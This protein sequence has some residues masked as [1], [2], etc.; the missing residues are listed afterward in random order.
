MVEQSTVNRLAV[1][2]IPTSGAHRYPRPHALARLRAVRERPRV[3]ALNARASRNPKAIGELSEMAAALH[4]MRAG[5]DVAQ[6]F[7]DNARYDLVI[8]DGARLL[9]VQ[10][11][12]GRLGQDGGIAFPTCSSQV[13]R[14]RGRMTYHG[15]CDLF[16]VYCPELDQ[17]YLVPVEVTGARSCTLRVEPPKNN[18]AAGV[19]WAADYVLRPKAG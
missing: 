5:Y 6:P 17:T 16:A 14:G 7:G 11:K 13:H 19:R 8:D 18:Q 3:Y 10:V 12:T 9:R 4:L 15:Q 2:S 1:G